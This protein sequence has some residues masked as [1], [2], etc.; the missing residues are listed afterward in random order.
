MPVPPS[1][2]THTTA[3]LLQ[4]IRGGNNAARSELVARCRRRLPTG[5][6]STAFLSLV[7][8]DLALWLFIV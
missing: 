3:H 6:V 2:N 5:V 4:Q 1:P 8:D 7:L